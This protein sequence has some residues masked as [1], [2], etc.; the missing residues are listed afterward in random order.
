MTEKEIET[1]NRRLLKGCTKTELALA[2][3]PGCSPH[4]ARRNLAAW[5]RICKPLH[6]KLQATGYVDGKKHTLTPRMVRLIFD[7]FGEP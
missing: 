7:Y 3:M 5:I 2:Y 4:N 6:G 1:R